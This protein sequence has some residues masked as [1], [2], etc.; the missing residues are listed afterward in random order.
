VLVGRKLDLAGTVEIAGARPGHG[1][2]AAAEDGASDLGPVAPRAAVGVVL[3]LGAHDLGELLIH[4]Q[5]H[6]LEPDPDGEREQTLPD[7]AGELVERDLNLL[8]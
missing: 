7:G 8:G 5:S 3:A 4:H 6:D 1:G 2:L